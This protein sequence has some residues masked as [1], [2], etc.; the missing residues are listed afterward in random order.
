M[1][2]GSRDEAARCEALG[3]LMPAS[4]R[5]AGGRTCPR[6]H[7]GTVGQSGTT[8][9]RETVDLPELLVADTAEWRTWLRGHHSKS[10]G[11]WLVLAKKGTTYPTTLSY[12]EALDEAICFGWIDGRLGRR[13]N[14]QRSGDDS[15]HETLGALG[16]NGTSLSPRGW[17][18][19]AECIGQ[20]KTRFG[21][22]KRMVGGILPTPDKRA[23][24]FQRIWRTP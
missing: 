8:G 2:S 16:L 17:A 19:P 23:W 7:P 14:A 12:D 11:V 22:P 3:P 18:P 5:I 20:G 1:L 4:V 15:H 10:Q 9:Y 21:R 13:D 6:T 24:R